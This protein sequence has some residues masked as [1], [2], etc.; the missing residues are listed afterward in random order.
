[1]LKTETHEKA[2]CSQFSI[3]CNFLPSLCVLPDASWGEGKG[4][5][6]AVKYVCLQSQRDPINM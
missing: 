1:M 3:I 6:G 2:G 5:G 4:G